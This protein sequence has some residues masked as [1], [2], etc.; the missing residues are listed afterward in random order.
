MKVLFVVS[1]TGYYRSGLSNPLGVLSIA[2]YLKHNGHDVKVYDRNVDKTKLE[3]LLKAYDPDVVGVSIVSSRGLKDAAK[4][5]KIIKKYNITVVW[6]GQMPTMQTELCFDCSA[7]DYIVMGE[8]EITFLEF[9]EKLG[10]GESPEG[11]Y[12]IAYKRDGED[13]KSVV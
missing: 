3:K 9:L 8:G 7:I 2:T 1:D 10:N 11:I 13:R 5:S 6:G 12:G 4:V